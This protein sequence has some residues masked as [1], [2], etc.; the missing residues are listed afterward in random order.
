MA[1]ESGAEWQ[2]VIA[3]SDEAAFLKNKF[4]FAVWDVEELRA[5]KRDIAKSAEL[6]L[7]LKGFPRNT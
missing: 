6:L 4:V 5:T 3:A 2:G 1:K 7:G